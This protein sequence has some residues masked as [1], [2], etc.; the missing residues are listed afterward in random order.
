MEDLQFN[1]GKFTDYT[2]GVMT[3]K[4]VQ[5]KRL[6]RGKAF[7][8]PEE[9]AVHIIE[10]IPRGQ[11]SKE[12]GRCT[13]CRMVKRRSDNLYSITLH[14]NPNEKFIKDTLVSEVRMMVK[15]A[16]DVEK[17]ENDAQTIKNRKK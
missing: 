9:S 3:V 15:R 4:D 10:N 17:A 5:T 8:N 7:I 13:H 14:F 16:T 2:V 6:I 1:V 11:R 12:I